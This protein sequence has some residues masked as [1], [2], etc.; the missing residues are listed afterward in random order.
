MRS[1]R[2]AINAFCKYCIYDPKWVGGGNWRQQVEKC[3]ST[4]CPLYE[5]RPTSKPHSQRGKRANSAA[6]EE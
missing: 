2:S 6:A 4:D 3:P 1:L 5:C